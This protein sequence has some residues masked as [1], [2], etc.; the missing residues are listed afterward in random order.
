[1]V[2]ILVLEKDSNSST[3]SALLQKWIWSK[4][5]YRSKFNQIKKNLARHKQEMIS[6]PHSFCLHLVDTIR[7]SSQH[8]KDIKYKPRIHHVTHPYFHNCI[9][10]HN[11]PYIVRIAV[12]ILAE[13]RK[14][15]NF[16]V[17]NIVTDNISQNIHS[18]RHTKIRPS[19]LLFAWD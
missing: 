16:F 12:V 8:N 1:M 10:E 2:S 7:N 18:V 5:R 15:I 9:K 11:L 13:V 17:L 6:Y 14:L 3:F 4:R 19:N